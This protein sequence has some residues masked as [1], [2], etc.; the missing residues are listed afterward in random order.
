MMVIVEVEIPG[1]AWRGKLEKDKKKESKTKI[2]N[3][4]VQKKE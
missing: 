1:S 4:E 2:L 3:G